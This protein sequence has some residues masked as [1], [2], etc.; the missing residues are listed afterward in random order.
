VFRGEFLVKIYPEILS[1]LIL[2][3]R[4]RNAVRAQSAAVYGPSHH[5]EDVRESAARHNFHSA[6]RPLQLIARRGRG[7]RWWPPRKVVWTRRQGWGALRLRYSSRF[8][9]LII[10]RVL[11][12]KLGLTWFD[13]LQP[14]GSYDGLEGTWSNYAWIIHWKPVKTPEPNKALRFLS[15]FVAIKK[16]LNPMIS[17]M[18]IRGNP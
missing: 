7:Y 8:D 16:F 10:R 15:S 12:L 13:T 2:L 9:I 18:E 3:L 14:N 11:N 4:C 17:L 1:T 6:A 5:S